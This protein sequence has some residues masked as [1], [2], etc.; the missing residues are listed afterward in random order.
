MNIETRRH[1]FVKKLSIASMFVTVFFGAGSIFYV[2]AQNKYEESL[3]L[4]RNIR[5]VQMSSLID[6]TFNFS[7]SQSMAATCNP[8]DLNSCKSLIEYLVTAINR[9]EDY[10]IFATTTLRLEKNSESTE[11]LQATQQ[12]I[13]NFSQKYFG[14]RLQG[15][16][17]TQITTIDQLINSFKKSQF[18]PNK[19]DKSLYPDFEKLNSEINSSITKFRDFIVAQNTAIKPSGIAIGLGILIILEILLFL[20]VNTIDITNNNADPEKGNEFNL[21]KIQAKVK[22][23]AS[24]I[25]L[26]FGVMIATQ[27][28][29]VSE[30][31]RIQLSHCREVNQQDIQFLNL[32]QSYSQ[33]KKINFVLEGFKISKLCNTWIAESDKENIQALNILKHSMDSEEKMEV[34]NEI[35]RIYAD[36]FAREETNISNIAK[37]ILLSSLI[38]N[39]ISMAL[40]SLFLRMDSADIG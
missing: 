5:A 14:K 15:L 37:N 35:A 11:N 39:V 29:L 25:F 19:N 12:K 10:K 21:R 4:D 33:T 34:Q 7:P 40:L 20:C 16:D 36:T 32:I 30:N 26:A 27:I 3:D 2:T 8:A 6:K 13:N 31:K 24:S 17:Q 1:R 22:P 38:F 9:I 18:V 28:V 23:L